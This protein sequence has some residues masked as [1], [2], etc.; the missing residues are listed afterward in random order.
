LFHHNTGKTLS[1]RIIR[2]L[3]KG[4][5]IW[6][7]S[8]DFHMSGSFGGI[9]F[10]FEMAKEL[11]PSILFIEDVD[12]WLSE[13]TVD[14]LKT[15][16]DGISRSSGVLTILTTN[17]PE[18]LPEALIDRPGRFHDVLHF[19]QPTKEV[20]AQMLAKWLPNVPE[21]ERLQA[22]AQTE[23]Y[24]GAHVYE[25]AAFAKMLHEQDEMNE[26]LALREAIK[27]VEEQRDLI[28]AIQLEGSNYKPRRDLY[29]R[30][31]KKSLGFTATNEIVTKR[32]VTK[33]LGF[34][35]SLTPARKSGTTTQSEVVSPWGFTQLPHRG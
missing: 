33:D 3:A 30:A 4:T 12:N 34:T 20:R 11:S 7:S 35:K 5:F 29:E 14:L 19:A 6:V 32:I 9:S 26:T 10:A 13:R 28:T 24:S 21:S 8:R 16:M 23:G 22:A 18:R 1:G 31:F 27:K 15:E 17:F 2:N 25:L